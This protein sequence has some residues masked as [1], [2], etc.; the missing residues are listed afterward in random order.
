MVLLFYMGYIYYYQ[1]YER[2]P[3]QKYLFELRFYYKLL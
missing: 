3:I 2:P 1:F